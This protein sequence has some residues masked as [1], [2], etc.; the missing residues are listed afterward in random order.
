MGVFS[1]RRTQYSLTAGSGD[2]LRPVPLLTR[3]SGLLARGASTSVNVNEGSAFSA[4]DFAIDASFV[5]TFTQ[6]SMVDRPDISGSASITPDASISGQMNVRGSVT[7]N[8]DVTIKDPVILAR[9]MAL[10]LGEDLAPGEISTFDLVLSGEGTAASS[11]YV[12]TNASPYLGYRV[13]QLAARTETSVMQIIGPERYDTDPMLFALNISDA[14]QELWRQQL[15]LWSLVD[16]SYGS[17]GRGDNVYLAGWTDDAPLDVSLDGA[18]WTDQRTTL[19]LV[20]LETDLQQPDDTLITSDRMMWAVRDYEGFGA[21]SPVDLNMQPG[22]TVSFRFTPL[23]DA[24]LSEVDELSIRLADMNLSSRRVPLYLWD[25]EA[26]TWEA[27]D[28]NREGLTISNPERYLGPENA[29]QLRLVADEI[30]GYLRI[31]RLDI[32]QAGRF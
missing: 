25:W 23:P 17:T 5:S 4:E 26:Q 10:H 15:L 11:P 2:V 20:E 9:G 28:V 1:P 31:G 32:E 29:V 30:G 8:T 6:E 12:S 22:E 21:L 3:A 24:V 27:L 19:Y 18:D 14:D 16:D 7:N 13:A